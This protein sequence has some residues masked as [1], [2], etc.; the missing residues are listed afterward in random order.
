M[1]YTLFIGDRSYS[2]WSLRGWL[3]FE[4]FGIEHSLK[5][6]SF[7]DAR[8]G[9][10]ALKDLQPAK[11]VPTVVIDDGSIIDDSLAIGRAGNPTPGCRHLAV[12]SGCPRNGPYA[13]CRNAFQLWRIA[14]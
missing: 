1:A 8:S 13:C 7:S 4:N 6:V 2:S 10:A 14:G 11:T 12:R 9:F 3:L 5:H